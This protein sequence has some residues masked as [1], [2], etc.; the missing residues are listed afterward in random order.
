[1]NSGM[2]TSDLHSILGGMALREEA[3]SGSLGELRNIN[4]RGLDSL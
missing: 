3:P 1:V 4:P 2:R